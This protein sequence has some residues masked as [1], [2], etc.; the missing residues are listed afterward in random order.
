MQWKKLK[1]KLEY[2]YLSKEGDG[3]FN[4]SIN[5]LTQEELI[6]IYIDE[7]NISKERRLMIKGEEYYKVENDILKRK[8]IRYE[9]E[10][11][12][13]DTTKPNNTLAHGFMKNLIDDKVNYL[14]SKPYTM[15]CDDENYLKS[16]QKLLGKRFQKI[17]S[18]LGIESSNKGIGWLHIYVNPKGEFKLMKIPSEQIIPLWVDNDHEELQAIIRYYDVETYT[19]RKRDYI[20]KVEYWTSD[21]VIYYLIE[22]G[23][24]ILDSEKY[25]N[26]ENFNGHFKINDENKGWG[27]VPFIPFKNNDFELP[28]LQFV[29]TLID[30]YDL[31][32]SDIANQLEEIKNIIYALKGYGGENL[33][34]FMRDLAYYKAVKLEEDG[35]VDTVESTINIEAAKT[36]YEALKK[37]IFDF[38]QGVDKNSDKLGNSPSGIALKFIY[39]GL[40]LKCNALEEW[41]KWSF[42]EL[43]YFSNKYLEFIGEAYSD[44]EIGIIFNRDIA[45]NESQAIEDAQNSKG[46]ISNRTIVANHPWVTDLEEELSQIEKENS[47]PED[48]MIINQVGALDE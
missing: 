23:K 46:V 37:D 5:L 4:N 36:H 18:K 17:L 8:M 14:L 47:T 2:Q 1:R 16:I 24:L 15:S 30:N 48:D 38:G 11:P 44:E 19:G 31:T 45:I 33:S 29:K 9:D 26:D 40:D 43:I 25:L 13:E 20:T 12:V 21:N 34:E 22:N 41:F 42:Q 27:K 10:S 35:A 28:D 39:S 6:K 7:F 32:R 3:M